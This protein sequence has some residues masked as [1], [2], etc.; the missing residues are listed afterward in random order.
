MKIQILKTSY[1]DNFSDV[2]LK[3]G[4]IVIKTNRNVRFDFNDIICIVSKKTNLKWLLRDYMNAHLMKWKTIGPDCLPDYD[5]KTKRM[6]RKRTKEEE[7]KVKARRRQFFEDSKIKEIFFN[8]KVE[9]IKFK[10]TDNKK[11]KE[12][13]DNNKDSYSSRIFS[14]AKDWGKLMQVE[15]NTGKK[16]QDIAGKTSKEADYD[17]ITGF[18]Y[19]A[20]VSVLAK[21]WKYGEELR[22]WHNLKTQIHDEGENANKSGGVLNPA[23]MN[24]K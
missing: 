10:V 17:G 24:F 23:L 7:A 4:H 21:Y 5:I 15:M 20:A 3:A 18:M 12:W 16:L 19:G 1:S 13:E 22:K 14:Y 8:N 2:T 6:L 9:G 11:L